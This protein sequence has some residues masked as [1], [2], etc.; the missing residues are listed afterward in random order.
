M[1]LHFSCLKLSLLASG[2]IKLFGTALPAKNV[3]FNITSILYPFVFACFKLLAFLCMFRCL[4]H[5][6]AAR[7]KNK[8]SFPVTC[9]A[10]GKP[11]SVV[12][13]AFQCPSSR[14]HLEELF[15]KDVS[16]ECK[17][18]CSLSKP[19]ILRS[20]SK[21]AAVKILLDSSQCRT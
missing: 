3:L 12:Q 20:I 5:T 21:D 16:K 13:A 8:E 18:L 17:N 2:Y 15:G 7:E 1:A 19:S 9:T 6:R 10:L 14:S 11:N 4:A